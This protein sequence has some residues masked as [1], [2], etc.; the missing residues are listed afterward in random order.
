MSFLQ[1]E[2]AESFLEEVSS[3]VAIP[4]ITIKVAALANQL[5]ADSSSDSC[6]RLIGATALAET[7]N[8]WECEKQRGTL[9]R[10]PLFRTCYDLRDS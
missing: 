2:T 5:P 6:D 10:Y 8:R 9:L 7:V 3:L 4:P 1:S